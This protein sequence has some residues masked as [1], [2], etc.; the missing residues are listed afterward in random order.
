MSPVHVLYRSL[1]AILAALVVWAPS[2]AKADY[3]PLP[4][5]DPA[6]H[7]DRS[8]LNE[9]IL[10]QATF[11]AQIGQALTTAI[12]DDPLRQGSGAILGLGAGI[13]VPILVTRDKP[14]PS[15]DVVY[16]NQLQRVGIT[17]GI[18]VTGLIQPP[19]EHELRVMQGTMAGLGLLGLGAA[20]LTKDEL[21]LT[22]GQAS[23]LG[24]GYYY[25]LVS[26]ALLLN[27]LDVQESPR[28]LFGGLL[29]FSNA[30]LA[31][32]FVLREHF[33]VNRSRIIWTSIGGAGGAAVGAGL[34]ALFGGVDASPVVMQSGALVGFWGGVIG[35]FL[36]TDHLD[37]FRNRAEIGTRG[38]IEVD[39]RGRLAL[40]V[41]LPQPTALPARAAGGAPEMAATVNLFDWRSR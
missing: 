12:F 19:F 10:N 13:L 14:V 17:N 5:P 8:G 9:L 29:V 20:L 11:G 2:M 16:I 37:G 27:I 6:V 3:P 22:P 25:G 1:V 34:G 33:D 28:G 15:A 18:L 40:G 30:G 23:A 35:V 26:G 41:P 31:A 39:E 21:A 38:L 7:L 4:P 36:L 24:A 32:A